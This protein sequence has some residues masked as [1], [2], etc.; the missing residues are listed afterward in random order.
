MQATITD[1]LASYPVLAPVMFIA[2]RSLAIIIPP[3]P[4]AFFDLAAIAAFGWWKG[5]LLAE[6]GIMAGASVSFLIARWLRE[7]AV[8]RMASLEKIAAWESALGQTR[9]FWALVLLRLPTNAVFDYVS[10]AA[11]LLKQL[12]FGTFFLASLIGNLPGTILFFYFGGL[13]YR[14][15][16]YQLLVFVTALLVLGAI[17]GNRDRVTGW[18]K[19]Y[20]TGLDRP[21]QPPKG[22]S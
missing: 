18:L 16:I 11:G 4:G 7:P 6:A 15:G 9:T 19:R 17:L 13:F 8:R 3:I 14:S 2:L 10:Y 21:D 22:Q 1:L 5:L 20:A 12:G